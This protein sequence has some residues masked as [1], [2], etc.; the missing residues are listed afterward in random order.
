M[1][2][3]RQW[4]VSPW[5]AG[6]AMVTEVLSTSAQGLAVYGYVCRGGVM[7]QGRGG[8]VKVYNYLWRVGEEK[9]CLG[10]GGMC[11]KRGCV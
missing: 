10:R 4:G 5:V 7:C 9:M 2:G 6:M 1:T 11:L 8:E 3:I